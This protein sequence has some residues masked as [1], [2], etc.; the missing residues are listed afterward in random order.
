[1]PDQPAETGI[2]HQNET[3]RQHMVPQSYLRRFTFNP[4]VKPK[5]QKIWAYDKMQRRVFPAAI[6]DIAQER[7]FNDLPLEILADDY[8]DSVRNPETTLSRVE[9][10]FKTVLDDFV[11]NWEEVGI[12]NKSR[13][14]L[15][16]VLA[17]Q[18]MR[19]RATRA[20]MTVALADLLP[21]QLQ[22]VLDGVITPES[23]RAHVA[24]ADTPENLARLGQLSSLFDPQR[25]MEVCCH[26]SNDYL[27][28]VG[29][30]E[31][32]V[33]LY[34]SD[35]PVAFWCER[36]PFDGDPDTATTIFGAPGTR[37]AFPV[38][39]HL[40]I[41][42]FERTA[43]A[44]IA[45]HDGNAVVC[46]EED[47]TH[48]NSLQIIGSYRQ[49]FCQTNTF[50]LA[51]EMYAAIPDLC[52]PDARIRALLNAPLLTEKEWNDTDMPSLA[53]GLSAF[54]FSMGVTVEDFTES[55]ERN[56]P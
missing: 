56:V 27:W 5:H 15:A 36:E 52:D 54:L 18:M 1:M 40:I 29:V 24:N 23:G 14:S 21:Q 25:M 37:L 2:P 44:D 53:S 22:T 33:P 6:A 34:T 32:D 47:V 3:R 11:A 46:G 38:T 20:R 17:V 10:W 28:F 43:W 51:E 48:L 4:T 42:L 50:D 9:D 31:Y 19:T 8:A 30:N 49:V 13:S 26:L 16:A 35:N 7:D 45:P 41:L 39:P 12:P 55:E